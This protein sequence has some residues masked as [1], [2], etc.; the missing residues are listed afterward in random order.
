MAS[1][2]TGS[3]RLNRVIEMLRPTAVKVDILPNYHLLLEF[4]N[5]EKGVFDVRPYIKGS[6]FGELK[7]INKFRNIFVNGMTVEWKSGQDICPDDLY[8]K[9]KRI[10]EIW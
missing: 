3:D 1:S 4:D 2:T 10:P 5:G 7:D 9:S 8:Y 6:W